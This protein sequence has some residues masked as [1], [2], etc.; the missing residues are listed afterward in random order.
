MIT[1]DLEFPKI[2]VFISY[3]TK[4]KEYGAAVKRVLEQ[5]DMECFL[6]HEDLK[7]SEEWKERILEELRKCEVFVPIL[8]KAFRESEWAPQEVGFIV[9]RPNAVVIPISI[10]GTMPYGFI[11]HLQGKRLLIEDISQDNLVEP[12]IKNIP[13]K[14]IPRMIRDVANAMS[15]R[16][17]EAAMRPLVPF[18]NL[19]T[20]EELNM[21][22][23]ASIDN[24]EVWSASRCRGTYLPALIK[25]FRSNID[26]DKLEALE[27]QIENDEWYTK[28]ES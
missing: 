19:F 12:I 23:D 22:V 3:S 6:A 28:I 2:S 21:I 18:F 8:S 20:K 26:P 9:S 13:R 5:Y 17:A 27:H 24:Y 15:F 25:L 1:S 7:I 11:N 10:D 4:E 14:I 16:G